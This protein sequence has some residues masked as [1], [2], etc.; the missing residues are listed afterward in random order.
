MLTSFH[1]FNISK[2]FMIG[3][4]II[5]LLI[6]TSLLPI[7]NFITIEQ[8]KRIEPK[9]VLELT[10]DMELTE[11]IKPIEKPIINNNI[12]PVKPEQ[13]E[14][15]IK[16]DLKEQIINKNIDINNED[17]NIEK[18]EPIQNIEKIDM[19]DSIINNINDIPIIS[20]RPE[21]IENQINNN[22]IK[23]IQ[24]NITP[25]I[26][27]PE[28]DIIKREPSNKITQTEKIVQNKN[29]II[30][31]KNLQDISNKIDSNLNSIPDQFINTVNKAIK[32][33]ITNTNESNKEEFSEEELDALEKYKNNI[34][35]TIQ[36]FAIANYPR[37]LQNR[38]IQGTVQLIFK[39]NDDGSI[40][41]V[42]HGP[43]TTAPQ[44]LIDAA[45]KALNNSAPFESNEVLKENNEFSIDIV[46]KLQ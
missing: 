39:L 10:N 4:F 7:S 43:N 31:N 5:A 42:I 8:E 28:T 16:P 33:A 46:Y 23:P 44:E 26:K 36:S 41:S 1:S 22:I 2:P 6:H 30:I 21:L 38:R 15:T 13:I 25:N 11:P 3:A 20:Q 45:I 37:K 24:P 40:L 34:R 32:P 29:S 18:P 14:Q 9:L 19:P 35:S 12:P 27:K 17:I